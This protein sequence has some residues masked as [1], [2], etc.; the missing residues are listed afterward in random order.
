LAQL[1]DFQH[2]LLVAEGAA[3]EDAVLELDLAQADLF[4]SRP[5]FGDDACFDLPASP[6]HEEAAWAERQQVLESQEPVASRSN[7]KTEKVSDFQDIEEKI[8]LEAS[9]L[10]ASD[11]TLGHE[12]EGPLGHGLAEG[13]EHPAANAAP[14]PLLP[15]WLLQLLAFAKELLGELLSAPLRQF[16]ELAWETYLHYRRQHKLPSLLMT[17]GGAG[18]LLFGFGYLMRMASDQYFEIGKAAAGFA[19]AAGLL[20]WGHT[21]LRQHARYAEFGSALLG[22]GV[23]LLYLVLFGLAWQAPFGWLAS[24]AV[25]LPLML[26]NAL[27]GTWLALRHQAKIVAAVSLLGGACIPFALQPDTVP[28]LFWAMLWLM[29]A[30]NAWLAKRIGWPPLGSLAFLTAATLLNWAV[31]EQQMEAGNGSLAVY[32]AFGYLFF[33]HLLFERG[34]R[35][36]TALQASEATGLAANLA[37]LL[38]Q[39]HAHFQGQPSE[40]LGGWLALH[41]ALFALLFAGLRTRIP[42]KMGALYLLIAGAFGALAVPALFGQTL[43]G[44]AWGIE[45]LALAA[46]GMLFGLPQVRREGYAVLLLAAGQLLLPLPMLAL[47][48]QGQPLFD[49]CTANLA[50]LGLLALGTLGVWH[51][52]GEKQMGQGERRAIPALQALAALAFL[53]LGWVGCWRMSGLGAYNA[54]LLPMALLAWL[55]HRLGNRAIEAMG[56]LCYLLPWMGYWESAH[57]VG[58]WHFFAQ[59]PLGKIAM[60]EAVLPLWGLQLFCERIMP[61]SRWLGL[62]RVMREAFYLGLPWALLSPVRRLAPEWMAFGL[63]GS[64]ALAFGLA[65]ALR[66]VPIRHTRGL[67]RHQGYLAGLGALWMLAVAAMRLLPALH[68]PAPFP[69]SMAAWAG[70]AHWLGI[71]LVLAGLYAHLRWGRSESRMWEGRLAKMLLEGASAWVLAT[72]LLLGWHGWGP[73]GVVALPL[74]M[75]AGLA[76]AKHCRLPLLERASWMLWALF[77]PALGLLGGWANW[78]E[79][80]AAGKIAYLEALGVLGAMAWLSGKGARSTAPQWA[81]AGRMAFL[82]LLPLWPFP[83]A[84]LGWPDELAMAGW[85]SATLAWLLWRGTQERMLAKALLALSGGACIIFLLQPTPLGAAAGIVWLGM[86]FWAEKGY[87]AEASSNPIR[88]L[89]ALALYFPGAA[90]ALLYQRAFVDAAGGLALLGAYAGLT[91][92]LGR[93][94]SVLEGHGRAAWLASVLCGGFGLLFGLL[95]VEPWGP[96]QSM[97]A[98]LWLGQQGWRAYREGSEHRAADV[99]ALHLGGAMAYSALALGGAPEGWA[100]VLLT[101]LYTLHAMLLLFHAARPQYAFLMRWAIAGFAGV[102]AK[103]Y[104]LDMAAFSD[105]QRVGVLM[106]VGV[107]L[108]A[109]ANLFARLRRHWEEP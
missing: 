39:L 56:L 73:A 15:L 63:V 41:A 48:A 44:L 64:T 17:V 18:A 88:P 85:A 32:H 51:F 81:R 53:A 40:A 95:G 71:G 46:V 4:W 35:P 28:P 104:F 1:G 23:A 60:L 78:L 33:Y 20:L 65:E 27:L 50:S 66:R 59:T 45:G 100:G 52:W 26:A 31:W 10:I 76:W 38:L 49:A 6:L 93:R 36:K 47:L 77:W 72:A 92:L 24:P 99:L 94:L 30:G 8:L 43:T 68:T 82:L 22:L 67:L 7:D 34:K 2:R 5:P 84:L 91:Q 25:H 75:L 14:E 70:F 12:E 90:A 89:L 107:L 37:L 80:S 79:M 61:G 62:A 83:T 86:V 101:G 87:R 105:G 102:V 98:L 109:G 3:K 74:A 54:G 69:W 29:A 19:G 55:G 21:L 108:L 13:Y 58:A 97:M 96:G 9:P 106:A 57:A 42:A 11:D 16:R 103:L